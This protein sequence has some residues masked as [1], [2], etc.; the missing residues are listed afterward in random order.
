MR[1]SPA[2]RSRLKLPPVSLAAVGVC[3]ALVAGL[4][5]RTVWP[6]DIE[7]KGDEAWSFAA[8]Q[9]DAPLPALGM[10]TSYDV[11][12][13]G[14]T[15]WVFVALAKLAGATTPPDL[16]RACQLANTLAIGLLVWFAVRC[17]PDRERE[18]WLWAA[19]LAAV[20]PLA[21]V[22][23]RKIWPPSIVP[24]LATLALI[25]WWHRDRRAG[26]FF[27]GLCSVLVGQLHPAGLFLALG[28][29]GWTFLVNR[30][31]VR[32]AY[33]AAGCAVAALTLVPWLL[34]ALDATG[35]G[36]SQRRLSNVA[37]LRFWV[38]WVTEAN[39]ISL[40]YSLGADF[41]DYL[42]H[43]VIG[44]VPTYGL[45][46]VHAGMI[47]CGLG[48]IGVWAAHARRVGWRAAA[49]EAAGRTSNTRLA[50]AAGLLG[51]GVVFTLT[52]LPVHRH[53]MCLTFPLMYLWLAC[54]AL[55]EGGARPARGRALLLA[56]CLLQFAASAGF[57][58]YVHAARRPIRGDYGTPYSAQVELGL[59]PR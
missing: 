24:L 50:V 54:L 27:W 14:G 15:V 13:P 5:L 59:P 51:F 8:T 7:F 42:R 9:A 41:W 43:P 12:H 44:G 58:G 20:N 39:G 21:V 36:I 32:W 19:A 17:V 16:A 38:N 40:A 34:Y 52:L 55:P 31:G 3:L 23:H 33:W 30:R 56:I 28:F 10:P 1:I 46:A 35:S 53:Y 26:A 18:P 6:A 48:A 47:A 22:F 45:A 29:A 49:A 11:R 25:A 4:L 57:L 2:I 37:T